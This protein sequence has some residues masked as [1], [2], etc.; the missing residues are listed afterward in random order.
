VRIDDS[1]IHDEIVYII[2]GEGM[3]HLGGQEK[4][5]GPGSAMHLPRSSSIV[6]EHRKG[7]YA[8]Y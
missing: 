1:H 2:D 6:W 5:I 3:L 8:S 7:V 4:V